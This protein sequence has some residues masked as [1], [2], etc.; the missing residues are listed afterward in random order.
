MM[1]FENILGV[2]IEVWF[3]IGLTLLVCFI[4]SII[5][6][7]RKKIPPG[8]IGLPV[9]GYLPFLTKNVHLKFTELSEKYGE[10]FSVKL[11]SELI[12]VLN[13]TESIREAFCKTEFLGRPPNSA[14]SILAN[15]SPF[16]A[17]NLHV[18]QEQRRFV[19][20][21]L[22]D[23]GLGKSKIE[24]HI[25]VEIHHFLKVLESTSGK[26]MDLM[27]PLTPSMSNNMGALVFGHRYEYDH[28][29]RVLLDESINEV[30]KVVVQ[31]SP[32]IFF[33][34]IRRIPFLQ[35]VFNL[36]KGLKAAE[37]SDNLFL[38]K[39]EEHRRTLDPKNIRDFI[40]SYFIEMKSRKEKDPN[41]SFTYD[42]LAA[43]A[44]DLFGAGSESVRTSISWCV[45]IM[46][47]FPEVQKKA[48]QEI[49]NIVGTDR[50]PEIQDQKSMPY[51]HSILLEV[52]RWKTVVPLNVLRYTSIDTTVGGYDVPKNTIVIGNFWAVLHD[53]KCW[54]NPDSFMP[55]R[56]LSP[57]KLSVVKSNHYIPF[58]VG[59][60]TCPGEAMAN[61]E[62]FL[63]FVSILQKFDIEFPPGLKPTFDA[64]IFTTYRPKPYKICFKPRS[65]VMEI[66]IAVF[67]IFVIY[68][69]KRFIQS[70]LKNL[71]PGP[72]GLPIVGYIPF[73]NK[74]VHLKFT[75]L[76]K[77]YGE[78]FSVRL[79]SKLVVVLN[80]TISI[81]EAFGKWEFLGRP[82]SSAFSLLANKSPFFAPN[83]EIWHEQRRFVVHAL[84]DLGLGRSKIEKCIQ[85][86]INY[87]LNVLESSKGK[88]MDLMI[89][90]TPSMSNNMGTLV[91]GHRYDYDHPDRVIFDESINEI[92]V[93]I[94]QTAYHIFFP[95]IRHI[96]FLMKLFSL[97]KGVEAVKRS[98]KILTKKIDEHI[99][100]LDPKNIRDFIDSYL[101]EMEA[102]RSKDPDTSFTYKTLMGNAGD[103]FGAG[104]E[105]VRTTLSW[106]TYT[107]AAFP[108]IQNKVQ[109]EIMDVLGADREPEVQDQKNMP[110]THAVILEIM[111]W[112]TIVPLNV[113][114]YTTAD[115]SVCGYDVPKHTIVIANFWALHH[116]PEHWENPEDF[117]PERFLASDKKSV[118][119]PT[120]YMPFSIGKRSCPGEGMANMEIFLYFV[121]ILQKFNIQLP[122]G[123]KSSFD[124]ELFITYKLKPHKLCFISRH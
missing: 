101:V 86:E 34:W 70:L 49:L 94:A 56:F 72:I 4:T 90:L 2:K 60:R 1:Q 37:R 79:G 10:V 30:S 16:F 120:H 14:F 121:S 41:T 7:L 95:W 5:R 91:Y 118:V 123:E 40:D 43:N 24:G 9:V 98:D 108:H 67:I 22:K 61:L 81:K 48:Q 92:S 93:I 32:Y 104:S 105:T 65:L 6:N 39:I 107:M 122:Q 57:D 17:P 69:F 85:E 78:V 11:G 88:S 21:A 52:M 103:L 89:P 68:V 44:G 115:T 19:V 55:E 116:N 62:I 45:Y 83:L 46:A 80:G 73:L 110:Y 87:F 114:R 74:D 77:K 113:L 58:S 3:A 71:P 109:K 63:Y 100:T 26:P 102:R 33:P 76:S 13:G 8:P 51:T 27:T 119:K 47:A 112:K 99:N 15:K 31:T 96:P 42:M 23:L 36:E 75:E 97:E 59:K 64:E 25:Q 18:W 53:P 124:A 106:C 12:V 111:R 84:K 82:P 54:E 20:H 28:P 38:K 50:D 117:I 29:D 66:W 35:R